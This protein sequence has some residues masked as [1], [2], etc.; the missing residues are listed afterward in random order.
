M[1]VDK[2][3]MDEINSLKN[4]MQVEKD[5]VAAMNFFNSGEMVF[6]QG[7]KEQKLLHLGE[8][9]EISNALYDS[10]EKQNALEDMEG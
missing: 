6:P 10:L 7:E 8:P 2:V 3:S 1:K 4:E 5:F 9:I